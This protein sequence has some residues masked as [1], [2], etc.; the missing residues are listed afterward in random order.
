MVHA[1]RLKNG[2]VNHI[3]RY[4]FM[5][6]TVLTHD[7]KFTFRSLLFVWDGDENWRDNILGDKSPDKAKGRYN[8]PLSTKD[9]KCSGILM[10]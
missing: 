8:R 9:F 7:G 5:T 2:Q 3:H 4:V 6:I 1:A 10:M